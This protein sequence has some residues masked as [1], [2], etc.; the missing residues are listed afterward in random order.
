MD[1]L[2]AYRQRHAAQYMERIKI[3][4]EQEEFRKKQEE[5]ELERQRLENEHKQFIF[6]KFID[7]IEANKQTLLT[8][9]SLGPV[10]DTLTSAIDV[11]KETK[12]VIGNM[13]EDDIKIKTMELF[14]AMNDNQNTTVTLGSHEQV[15]N[16][17]LVRNLMNQLLKSSGV[18]N[19]DEE[20]LQL[21]I[22]MDCSK[23]EELA[24]Q[25]TFEQPNFYEHPPMPRRRTRQPRVRTNNHE[26]NEQG[27]II[28]NVAPRRRGRPPRV[29]GNTENQITTENRR[30][31]QRRRPAQNNLVNQE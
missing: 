9:I 7:F 27:E 14:I 22:E 16:S 2:I 28:P 20:D 3:T 23:D 5:E 26:P 31:R 13:N 10:I 30:P 12:Q 18:L 6:K 25:L 11:L 21:E 29:Q 1:E 15:D 17:Q 4:Q 8:A 19:D 24:V